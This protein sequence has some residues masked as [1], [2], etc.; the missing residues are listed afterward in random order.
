MGKKQSQQ[1]RKLIKEDTG[2]KKILLIGAAV[3]I[4]IVIILI[5]LSTSGNKSNR[6]KSFPSKPKRII[7]RKT[8]SSSKANVKIGKSIALPKK[9]SIKRPETPEGIR[10]VYRNVKQYLKQYDKLAAE[11]KWTQ[12]AKLAIKK[13]LFVESYYNASA[14]GYS[15]IRKRFYRSVILLQNDMGYSLVTQA[16]FEK[17]YTIPSNTLKQ[18]FRILAEELNK[19]ESVSGIASQTR[20]ADLLIKIDT[21]HG[22][23]LFK[24]NIKDPKFY[25]ILIR[26]LNRTYLSNFSNNN[27]FQAKWYSADPMNLWLIRQLIDMDASK[28]TF[29]SEQKSEKEK[30]SKKKTKKSRRRR[31]R[32]SPQ[33][34]MPPMG[35]PPMGPGG[36]M[37][38]GPMPGMPGMMMPEQRTQKTL[39]L[40]PQQ[41]KI[42]EH[43]KLILNLLVRRG[44]V[45]SA[46]LI[47]QLLKSDKDELITKAILA[48]QISP[49]LFMRFTGIYAEP[50]IAPFEKS[51][52]DIKGSQ[53]EWNAIASILAKMHN[54]RAAYAVFV[55]AK[56]GTMKIESDV[57][58]TL[59]AGARKYTLNMIDKFIEAKQI[60]DCPIETLFTLWTFPRQDSY[61]KLWDWLEEWIPGPTS[62]QSD[63]HRN[64]TQTGY[65]PG[66]MP[67]TPGM[68]N[69]MPTEMP[70][71]M[72]TGMPGK[73]QNRAMP[74]RRSRRR[75]KSSI[76]QKHANKLGIPEKGWPIQRRFIKL[77]N[78]QAI[79]A[80]LE[81]TGKIPVTSAQ[82]KQ[83]TQNNKKR[84]KKSKRRKYSKPTLVQS[85]P[86]IKIKKSAIRC[87]LNVANPNHKT[88]FR[89][90][91]DDDNV[92]G[93]ARLGVCVLDDKESCEKLLAHFWTHPLELADF[94]DKT[95]STQNKRQA[96]II[97]DVNASAKKLAVPLNE[98]GLTQCGISARSAL[99]YFDYSPAGKAFLSALGE[100]IL[101]KDPFDEP[102]RVAGAI[103]Q[104][105]EAIGDWNVPDSVRTLADLIASAG[106]FGLRGTK[107]RIGRSSGMQNSLAT[108]VRVKALE[109]LGRIGD[110]DALNI[111]VQ[112]ATFPQ[113]D[114]YLQT[115]ARIALARRG[116]REATGLFL[117]MLDPEKNL[118]NQNKMKNI[119]SKLIPDI[120]P[121]LRTEQ[122]VALLGIS[123]LSRIDPIYMQRAIELIKKLGQVKYPMRRGTYAQNIQ[124]RYV[125]SLLS[126]GQGAI[127]D[128]IADLIEMSALEP[129]ARRGNIK[130]PYYWNRLT[131][132]ERDKAFL[133]MIKV[134][135]NKK[136][137]EE[138]NSLVRLIK[139]ILKREQEMFQPKETTLEQWDPE[140]YLTKFEY[141]YKQT[142]KG[143]ANI[144]IGSPEFPQMEENI[145]DISRVLPRRRHSRRRNETSAI[146]QLTDKEQTLSISY[147]PSLDQKNT[148]QLAVSAA[149]ELITNLPNAKRYIKEFNKFLLY[150]YHANLAFSKKGFNSALKNLVNI[151]ANPGK[152]KLR[153]YFEFLA[154]DQ[155]TKS[156]SPELVGI[157]GQSAS[158]SVKP[159]II[160]KLIDGGM[161]II[162]KLFEKQNAG[163]ITILD[164]T[165]LITSIAE[166]W[167][168]VISTSRYDNYSDDALSIMLAG[169]QLHTPAIEWIDQI[170]TK[171]N[172]DNLPV[173]EQ[174]VINAVTIL[175]TLNPAG[176]KELLQLYLD[177]LSSK[178]KPQNI[179]ARKTNMPSEAFDRNIS[180]RKN[181]KR[182]SRPKSQYRFT[183]NSVCPLII[184]AIG[185]MTELET[186]TV[187]KKLTKERSDMLGFIAIEIYKKDIDTGKKLILS[188]I[189]ASDKD[190]SLSQQIQTII[191]FLLS[192]PASP[193]RYEVLTLTTIVGDSSSAKF[194]LD[195]LEQ[196]LLE[197]KFPKEL[198]VPVM[199]KSIL[200]GLVARIRTNKS[201]NQRLDK[202]IEIARHIKNPELKKVIENIEKYRARLKRTPKR[203][204]RSRSGRTR[205][206]RRRR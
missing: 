153:Q 184:R 179:S 58:F 65:M 200:Q 81:K 40:S 138:P 121:D 93:L 192:K 92:G 143:F 11:G 154:I 49:A 164:R 190:P 169:L 86:I 108:K 131:D 52:S 35:G 98:D 142:G 180:N 140:K 181:Q 2:N 60:Q 198:D 80:F 90:L 64:R 14:A 124:E 185:D 74:P 62:I 132:E 71:E 156:E 70:N 182:T 18:N 5:V 176:N 123:K 158:N 130:S 66:Q 110:K 195:I 3:G 10:D 45:T 102:A 122:D 147:P 151:L 165:S 115:A 39:N 4:L 15:N 193:F 136:H 50:L 105:I 202:A 82:Q 32:K 161:Y 128:K 91:I 59:A 20:L 174:A 53:S 25:S 72:M 94:I 194:C 77:V 61:K 101:H 69:T 88:Y 178:I 23:K 84:K 42:Y 135:S 177:I 8:E 166:P 196:Q 146:K 6:Q 95:D 24:E 78:K 44:G 47:G 56:T 19:I 28:I 199:F 104:I 144:G 38:E 126:I 170:I 76:T 203:S 57:A 68:E 187:L 13:G 134:L 167:E 197:K 160:H 1:T 83:N 27:V 75:R 55:A 133:Y 31:R 46:Y 114:I 155:L 127:L 113:G 163:K 36:P 17:T 175:H 111:I 109:V 118:K 145:P 168:T 191:T 30:K 9:V 152:G 26:E 48:G 106:D 41:R 116:S 85:D 148:P 97:I 189:K 103:C 54:D 129:S 112:L 67:M 125:L 139:A 107:R 205:S 186:L 137:F 12:L 16:E 37:M 119:T 173:S 150:R 117:D 188:A 21:P 73:M 43:K 99:I 63:S 120:A 79:L 183:Y 159:I 100:F 157:L 201:A 171:Q 149:L 33:N 172:K 34:G 51:L 7:T 206:R 162:T 141:T 96:Q 89:E 87:L 22:R 29:N 204:Q